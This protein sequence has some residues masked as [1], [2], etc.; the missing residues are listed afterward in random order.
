MLLLNM[1]LEPERV[2]NIN[3]QS[4]NDAPISSGA[5]HL[6]G[7]NGDTRVDEER[8][9]NRLISSL[10]EVLDLISDCNNF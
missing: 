2:E 7:G 8:L 4:L 6:D 1:V 5:V 10:E 9:K 3:R